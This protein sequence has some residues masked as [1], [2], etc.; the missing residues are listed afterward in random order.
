[1]SLLRRHSPSETPQ[2]GRTP[3][4]FAALSGNIEGVLI[5]LMQFG[6]LVSIADKA[7]FGHRLTAAVLAVV[8][9]FA[10]VS[11]STTDCWSPR[12]LLCTPQTNDSQRGVTALHI[13]C[14]L[15]LANVVE[16]LLAKK[17]NMEAP[18]SVRDYLQHK[19]GN[20]DA[21]PLLCERLIL[22]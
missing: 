14:C 21:R 22:Q 3:L 16:V 11:D 8:V 6:I 2:E 5:L 9:L 19:S 12:R 20:D 13:A 15:G 10:F 4:H 18:D 1:M 17:A 7:R